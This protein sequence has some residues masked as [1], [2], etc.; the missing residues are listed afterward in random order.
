MFHYF[1][2]F[3]SIQFLQKKKLHLL[4][5]YNLGKNT[6]PSILIFKNGIRGVPLCYFCVT[7]KLKN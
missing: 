7:K 3:D 1:T 5:I 4:Q 2:A 6:P